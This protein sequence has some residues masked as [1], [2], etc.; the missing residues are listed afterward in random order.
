MVKIGQLQR[1][2][3][4]VV[5]LMTLTAY[6]WM[7]VRIHLDGKTA[8]ELHTAHMYLIP[9]LKTA[10]IKQFSSRTARIQPPFMM[11]GNPYF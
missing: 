1:C 11:S 2:L 10:L 9:D 3:H 8:L 7:F 5:G 6:G 4:S